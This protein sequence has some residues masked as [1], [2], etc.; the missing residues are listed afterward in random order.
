MSCFTTV[1]FKYLNQL[2]AH[3][4]QRMR[5]LWD[6]RLHP[7]GQN[8]TKAKG[9]TPICYGEY[10]ARGMCRPRRRDSTLIPDETFEVGVRLEF[11]WYHQ[12]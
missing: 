3:I 9:P 8:I 4:Q 5:L 7:F 6:S 12:S 2:E 11:N 10:N 1:G